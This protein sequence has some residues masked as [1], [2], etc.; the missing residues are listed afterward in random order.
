MLVPILRT[1]CSPR[2]YARAFIRAWR[3]LYG[4]DFPTQAQCGVLYAQWMVETGGSACWNWN[5]GNVKVTQAQVDAGA[6]WID[7]PGTWEMIDGKRVVLQE[8][9]PGRRFRAFTSLDVA[10]PEHLAF[11]RNKRYGPSWPYVE[12]GDPSG[13]AYAL[14][15]QGYYTASADAYA[16]AMVGHH[17]RF[18]GSP[19]FDDALRLVHA[20]DDEPTNPEIRLDLL[21]SE[22]PP[23]PVE[24]V[25]VLYLL[26]DPVKP[27]PPDDAA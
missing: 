20:E 9:D 6:L 2:D 3:Q 11:L 26:P 7:L 1:V 25:R 10:M 16:S 23:P 14:K 8:G 13:F 17:K 5:I 22:R 4:G 12:A 27:P 21:E 18:M 15:R 24:D 19:S